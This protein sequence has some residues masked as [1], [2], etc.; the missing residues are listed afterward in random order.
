MC[1]RSAVESILSGYNA[2]IMAY[3]QTGSGKTHTLD[4]FYY[5]QTNENKGLIPRC[6]EDVFNYIESS[7][8]DNYS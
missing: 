5:D 7:S 1:G 2:T 6:L 3:G 4:G 8:N